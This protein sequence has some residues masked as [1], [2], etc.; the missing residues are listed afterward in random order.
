MV[1]PEV[2]AVWCGVVWC[3]VVWCGVVWCGVVWCG[4]AKALLPEGNG[5]DV[6]PRVQ[7]NERAVCLSVRCVLVCC[8]KAGTCA[9]S[10]LASTALLTPVHGHTG[11]SGPTA[12]CVLRCTISTLCA[13]PHCLVLCTA[14]HCVCPAALHLWA[15]GIGQCNSCNALPHC[16]W[17]VGSATR[18]MHCLTAWGQWAVQLLQ[19]TASLP[20]GSGQWNS[21]NALPHCVVAVGSGTPAMCGPPSWGD[22]ESCPV[23]GRCRQNGTRAMHCL[24][25][26]GQWAVQLVQCTASVPGGSGQCNSCNALPHCVL[27]VRRGTPAMRAPP[28]LGGRGGLPRRRSLHCIASLSVGSGQWGSCNAM[29]HCL[30]AKGSATPVMHCHIALGQWTGELVQCNSTLLGGNWQCNSCNTLPDCLGAVGSA[31]HA[32][33]CHTSRWRWAVE[34]LQCAAPQLGGR[35]LLHRRRSLP[36][37]RNSCNALPHCLGAMGSASPTIHCHTAW[38]QWAVEL[39]AMRGPTS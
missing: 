38:G 33:H 26:C 1:L 2:G 27:A 14:L 29:P 20:Q 11:S 36:K 31:T 19:Y 25:T 5:R 17:A 23:G 18:T 13:V 22:G 39:R 4:V 35:G 12:P 34:F 32:I 37:E 30:G 15:V 24:T 7:V 28:Q 16:L 3:G 6:Y 8:C 10:H 9:Q 21:C